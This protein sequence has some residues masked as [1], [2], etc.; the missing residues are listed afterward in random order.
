LTEIIGL[1]Y[2][3]T[4]AFDRET[5]VFGGPR[6][7]D[8]FHVIVDLLKAETAKAK[9]IRR[10]QPISIYQWSPSQKG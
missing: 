9:D 2:P 1:F 8:T 5:Y 6:F 10:V 7:G 4:G 3:Q